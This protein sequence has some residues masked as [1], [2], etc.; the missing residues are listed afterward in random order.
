MPNPSRS[1]TDDGRLSLGCISSQTPAQPAKEAAVAEDADPVDDD[2]ERALRDAPSGSAF[3]PEAALILGLGAGAGA[4]WKW[5]G[6]AGWNP[7]VEDEGEDEDEGDEI[8]A[9]SDA[10]AR[11]CAAEDTRS[12]GGDGGGGGGVE[13]EVAKDDALLGNGDERE[14]QWPCVL[15]RSA[16]SYAAMREGDK[17]FAVL[18][19][20]AGSKRSRDGDGWDWRTVVVG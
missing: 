11:D 3:V 4:E 15:L 16:M 9:G 18:G 8:E 1:A 5:G 20:A 14:F 13:V 17:R 7:V 12:G 2:E 19:E 6:D 10:G